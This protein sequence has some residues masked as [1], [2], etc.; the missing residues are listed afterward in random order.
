[1]IFQN[2]INAVLNIINNY[3]GS[4]YCEWTFGGSFPKPWQEVKG[5]S[6]A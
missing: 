1:M 3:I 5:V 4:F 6:S 2:D